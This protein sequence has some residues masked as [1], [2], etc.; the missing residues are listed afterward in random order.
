MD[1]IRTA[2]VTLELVKAATPDLLILTEADAEQPPYGALLDIDE[3]VEKSAL[4]H[5]QADAALRWGDRS[6][7]FLGTVVFYAGRFDLVQGTVL[8]LPGHYPRGAT[9]LT[10]RDQSLLFRVIA[11]HLSLSQ[12][13]RAVQMRTIGQYLDR[14]PSMP[15]ILAGDLNEWRPWNGLA[16]SKRLVGHSFRG[17]SARSFP[18]GRPLLPLDRILATAPAHVKDTGAIFSERARK[19]SDHLPVRAT[20]TLV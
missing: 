16:F 7:G 8:D 18:S 10:F 11:T 4:R 12:A 5:A 19:T 2:D 1:P 13:L 6:S 14:Q 17:P 3:I 9:I 20:V 15:T